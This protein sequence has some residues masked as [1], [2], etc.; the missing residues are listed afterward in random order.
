M[1]LRVAYFPPGP[2]SLWGEGE[3]GLRG[4]WAGCSREE[5]DAVRAPFQARVK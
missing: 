3:E 5:A 2:P 4:G 1:L